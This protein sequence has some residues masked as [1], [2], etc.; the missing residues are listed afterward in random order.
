MSD[1]MRPIP[2]LALLDW[3]LT[4][5]ESEGNI[6]GVFPSFRGIPN[7]LLTVPGGRVETPFGPAAGPHTQL[8]QNIIS[9]Y[10]GGAR[11]FELKTVQ[12]LD[13]EDLPVS[14]PCISAEDEGYNVEWSTELTVP[15]ALDEYVKAWFV[16]KILAR[17]LGLGAEDGF[18]F[19]MSVGYNLK[20]IQSAKI[21][22]F[23]EGLR[24]A[25]ALPIW[26]EC[27]EAAR[28]LLPRLHNVDRAFLNAIDPKVCSAITLS[29][30]H[31][32]P[33]AEIEAIASYLLTKKGLNTY[34]KLNPTLLGYDA[35]RGILDEMGYDYISFDRHHFEQDLQFEDAVP[36]LTRLMALADSKG[37]AFGVKLSNTFPSDIVDGTLPGG[38]M[39]LSGKALYPL[40]L[41]LGERLSRAFDGNLRI[42]WSGGADAFNIA[43]L[44]AA[45]VWPVTLATTLLKPGGYRRLT[46]MAKV[47]SA[48]PYESEQHVSTDGLAALAREAFSDPHYRKPPKPLPQRKLPEK[49]PLLDCFTAPCKGGCP[50]SQDIPEYI[51]L[52]GEGR[53]AQALR[54][55]LDK[56]PLP[57]ITGTIC[58]HPCMSKCTRVFY[59]SP[60]R[61]REAKL[62]AAEGGWDVVLPQIKP[63]GERPD[64]KV[65]VVGGGPA[66]MSAAFFLARAGA[67]VTLFELRDALGGIV[68]HIIPTFR[69]TPEA[70]ERDAA[71]LTQLG[72]DIRLNTPAPLPEKLYAQGYTHIILAVGAWS[73]GHLS[74]EGEPAMNALDFLGRIREW[75]KLKRK[76]GHIVVVGGGNT[77]MDAA[78]AAKR[79]PGCEKV[80]LVYRRTK[81]YMPAETEELELALSESV[82]FR[83]LL[84]PVAW[85]GQT[86]TCNILTLG[87]VDSSGRRTPVET[88]ETL[89]IPADLVVSAVGE[90]VDKE[91][92][93]AYHVNDDPR[94][95]VVG[96]ALRG[97]ATVV[98]AIADATDAAATIAGASVVT[99]RPLPA[100]RRGE[101]M[102]KKGVLQ[103]FRSS[104]REHERCL[105]CQTL[106][107]NCVGVCPNRANIAVVV[108]TRKTPQIVHVDGMCNECGNC[109]T[110]CPYASA[111]YRDKFTVFGSVADFQKSENNGFVLLDAAERLVRV[112]LDGVTVDADLT[113]EDSPLPSGV[114]ELMETV[115]SEYPHLLF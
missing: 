93:E 112:R 22:Q 110:F 114:Q 58:A 19:N 42:S 105:E 69:I 37:L 75:G 4:E 96:D 108:P 73:P 3:V 24:N 57:H 59:E 72:V 109:E 13:G 68:R 90:Q 107:E 86:L 7:K 17:E 81:R 6:F 23:I 14:K 97:P 99:H 76:P 80:S 113:D 18:V 83:E 26:C 1:R 55:I 49:V 54:V 85:D 62:A 101:A 43:P 102:S 115:V 84:S 106:C 8:A 34:V 33:P 88:G 12:T 95:F 2:I 104:R 36:M 10:V 11:F 5:H 29:T 91:T 82:A 25:A 71:L 103:E 50:I 45:G 61:I 31:G 32:C 38:E 65:A 47:L 53:K 56:N 70:I 44:F 52:L 51:R 98:E 100:G 63:L 41:A 40:T 21:D 64:L 30:L 46:Q 111:P 77:A 92:L 74:L 48:M 20:G 94:V 28:T 67:S 78:R 89:T 35:A 15:Q 87:E 39:Y 60:V 66:G 79:L 9:A 16:L 27:Q